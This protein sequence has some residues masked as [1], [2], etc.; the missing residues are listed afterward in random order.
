[1]PKSSLPNLLGEKRSAENILCV[2]GRNCITTSC[3]GDNFKIFS[4]FHVD[5]KQLL[6]EVFVICS[7]LSM[8][9]QEL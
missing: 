2:P 8:S 7:K 6:D 1:M 5:I 4:F 9:R 3:I